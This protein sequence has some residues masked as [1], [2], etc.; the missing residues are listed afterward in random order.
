MR[1]TKYDT[2]GACH[3]KEYTKEGYYMKNVDDCLV[4]F[5][6]VERG[7]LLDV[8]CGDGLPACK[9]AEMGFFVTG[10]DN[11]KKGLELANKMCKEQVMWVIDDIT[12]FE[13]KLG[14]TD[15]YDYML[16]LDVIEHLEDPRVIVKL[17]N[18]VVKFAIL[19]TDDKQC[20]KELGQFHLREYLRE[21]I[22]DMFK[23]FK[24]EEI[25]IQDHRFFGYKIW[26]KN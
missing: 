19:I 25:L 9:L 1:Y 17:M 20:R 15:W 5:K 2:Q 26:A 13:K 11:E 22:V 14:D 16:C 23:G 8:G 21:E 3:W 4:Q 12:K 18:K 10:V 24:M 7:T 6:D